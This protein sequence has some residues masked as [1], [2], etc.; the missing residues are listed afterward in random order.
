MSNKKLK[1]LYELTTLI[2]K[3][4][5]WEWL[6]D[7]DLIA[8][9]PRHYKEPFFVSI[10]GYQGNC[11][12]ISTYYGESGLANIDILSQTDSGFSTSYLMSDLS[13]LTCYFANE[14]ELDDETLWEF[15]EFGLVP[16]REDR[17]FYFLSLRPRFYPVNPDEDEIERLVDV[18]EGLYV[19]LNDW[20]NEKN[21]NPDWEKSEILF[22]CEDEDGWHLNVIQQPFAQREYDEFI[23][24]DDYVEELLMKPRNGVGLAMEYIYCNMPVYDEKNRVDRPLNPLCFIAYDQEMNEFVDTLFLDLEE[25]EPEF[26]ID[27]LTNYIEKNGIPSY[28][29]CHNPYIETTIHNLCERL[30]IEMVH[31]N[32]VDLNGFMENVIAESME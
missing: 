9:Q 6:Y 21:A 2:A 10:M 7:V 28:V 5:P 15:E 26:A 1:R 30:D 32:L 19:A 4:E 31:D 29:A 8:I 25:N 16:E 23:M 27:F 12:G 18:Y 22:N 14:D 20:F 17:Y 3:M 11:Y 24:N 13:C